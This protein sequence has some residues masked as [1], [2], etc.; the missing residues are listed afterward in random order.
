MQECLV[1]N[2]SYGINDLRN[3]IQYFAHQSTY[4]NV[5]LKIRADFQ[6]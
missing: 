1:I 4:R 5:F 6:D 3:M 2:L